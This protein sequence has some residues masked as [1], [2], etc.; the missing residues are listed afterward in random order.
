MSG[1][2]ILRDGRSVV[3]VY[4]RDL[5][6]LGEGDTVGVMRTSQVSSII[7]FLCILLHL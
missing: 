4:G 1:N 7:I 3:E 2:S 6:Q 5:D